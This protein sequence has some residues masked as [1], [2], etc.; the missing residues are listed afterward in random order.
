[1]R[2]SRLGWLAFFFNRERSPRSPPFLRTPPRSPHKM[3]RCLAAEFDGPFV[4]WVDRVRHL[5]GRLATRL[6]G[7][8]VKERHE[9]KQPNAQHMFVRSPRRRFAEVISRGPLEIAHVRRPG[10]K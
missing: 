4:P 5:Q 3:R 10:L 1:M 6:G 9:G 7:F 2:V 8:A